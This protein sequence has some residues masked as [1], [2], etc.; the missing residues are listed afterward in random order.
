MT[1]DRGVKD[2]R[3]ARVCGCTMLPILG[4]KTEIPV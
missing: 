2:I 4:A 1:H 3:R